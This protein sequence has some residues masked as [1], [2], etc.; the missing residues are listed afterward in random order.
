MRRRFA[1]DC[2]LKARKLLVR[3]LLLL[4]LLTPLSVRAAAPVI[5]SVT[6]GDG[7]QSSQAITIPS[8][9]TGAVVVV[10]GADDP[11][12]ELGTGSCTSPHLT[13]TRQIDNYVLGAYS[14]AI[15][16][17][18]NSGAVLTNEVVT[19]V[20]T[21]EE[22]NL[23][24]VVLTGADTTYLTNTHAANGL[25]N[26]PTISLA[27]TG[28]TSYVLAI[29]NQESNGDDGQYTVAGTT[30]LSATSTGTQDMISMRNTTAGGGTI[31]VTG[32][33]SDEFSWGCVAI[34]MRSAGATSCTPYT[35][36]GFR[37]CF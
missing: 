4:S 21:N 1:Y 15:Y 18:V 8:I 32:G 36:G 30:L 31:T 7:G 2:R 16:T 28:T 25:G 6:E 37:N 9:A 34:E 14:V 22:P 11:G 24:G 23:T 5:V 19:L 12:I 3:V 17:A 33:W 35:F 29:C 26:S 13:F 27:V 20:A 10:L